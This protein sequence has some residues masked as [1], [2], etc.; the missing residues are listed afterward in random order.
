MI[1]TLIHLN[2]LTIMKILI[3]I[4]TFFIY[5]HSVAADEYSYINKV[6]IIGTK[7]FSK[8]E[9][10]N[11]LIKKKKI[12]NM[13]L[14]FY[15]L[16]N[17]HKIKL[18]I[19]N[20]TLLLFIQ[21]KPTIKRISI[22]GNLI[23]K[24]NLINVLTANLYNKK[25]STS[26]IEG[27]IDSLTKSHISEGYMDFDFKVKTKYISN[28]HT[29]NVHLTIYINSNKQYIVKDFIF[30]GNKTLTKKQISKNLNT[31]QKKWF[32]LTTSDNT[33]TVENF[34]N[35]IKAIKEY[36][37]NHGFIDIIFKSIKIIK[38]KKKRNCF[39]LID[40]DEGDLYRIGNI[41][42][43]PSVNLT[44][45][46]DII[47]MARNSFKENQ[48]LMIEYVNTLQEKIQA[49]FTY[50][51]F[52]NVKINYEVVNAGK[53]L[54]NLVFKYKKNNR[55]I[56][57]KIKFNGNKALSAEGL[58]KL[59]TIKEGRIGSGYNI[60]FLSD[61]L[62]K[63][64][65]IDKIETKI[66]KSK[67]NEHKRKIIFNITE[68]GINKF[69][70][71]FVLDRAGGYILNCNADITDFLKMGHDWSL[72]IRKT[73]FNENIT[74]NYFIP[75]LCDGMTHINYH[76]FYRQDIIENDLLAIVSTRTYGFLF[77]YGIPIFKLGKIELLLGG[78]RTVVKL[79]AYFIYPIIEDFIN[80][81][82]HVYKDYILGLSLIYD[83]TGREKEPNTGIIS[84]LTLTCTPPFSTLKYFI[85]NY[86]M[87][88][89]KQI[90][91]KYSISFYCN[92]VYGDKYGDIH[93]PDYPFFKNF[94]LSGRNNVRGF[95]DKSLGPRDLR[96]LPLG[97]NILLS[98]KLCL[99]MPLPHFK[100]QDKFKT[101]IFIDAGQLYN[102]D[103][104]YFSNEPFEVSDDETFTSFLRLSMGFA[105]T[106]DTPLG[107]PLEFLLAFPL[108]ATY[109]DE[110]QHM[111]IY[112]GTR[113]NAH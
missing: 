110:V 35:D 82:G 103:E 9:V 54:A 34:E 5:I 55:P 87:H 15:E 18:L 97:G 76:A 98:T 112:F 71:G 111:S 100:W 101:Q 37:M 10:Y 45:G 28:N 75:R 113:F 48:I 40:L 22:Y 17:F 4:I 109:E 74:F 14:D 77:T 8:E 16:K 20:K 59:L 39:I 66:K 92:I 33:L 61:H 108:N 11:L 53:G 2:K 85:I 94:Y 56:I 49:Y 52:I 89:F 58:K 29:T 23:E 24:T 91:K 69:L 32:I 60:D 102:T 50:K 7:N 41:I 27:L 95:K 12:N 107:I 25:L 81:N 47:A 63:Q 105:I 84:K 57:N 42:M 64:N 80:R 104:I 67:K 72:K 43:R 86:D 65:Y 26:N 96:E 13:L 93:T 70:I 51:Y 21:E 6:K 30:Y 31:L 68:K 90:T 1:N 36:Y 83:S 38:N 79:P 19:K 78:D 106:W 44:T 99:H 62:T 73:K 3:Y 46:S 88:A